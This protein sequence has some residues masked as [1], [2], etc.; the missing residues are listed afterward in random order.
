MEKLCRRTRGIDAD[1]RNLVN[2]S[3]TTRFSTTM[4]LP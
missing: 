3:A 1:E 4:T 2:G